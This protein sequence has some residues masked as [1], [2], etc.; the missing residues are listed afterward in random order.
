MKKS[1][2]PLL[3]ILILSSG[4]YA[5]DTLKVQTFTWDDDHRS[6]FFD[7]PDDD[8]VTYRK[9]LLRYNMRCHDAAVGNGSVGCY[10]WD[11]SCN[12]FITDPT[13]VDSTAATAPDYTISNF[14]GSEFP[15]N[16]LPT[17]SY[18]VYHQHNA[19]LMEG[20]NPIEVEFAP[21]GSPEP[22]T[23]NTTSFRYQV[24]LPGDQ[25]S[26]AGLTPGPISGLKMNLLEGGNTVGFF[27]IKLKNTPTDTVGMHPEDANLE[28]VYFKSTD[29]SSVGE[30]S[31]PFYQ[32]FNWEG[33]NL[34]MDISFTTFDADDAPVFDFSSTATTNAAIQSDITIA[35]SNV[36]FG[37]AGMMD[38]QKESVNNISN[39]ITIAFWSFGNPAILPANTSVAEGFDAAGRRQA[40]VHLPW[41]NGR[42]YWDCGN[43]GSGYDRIDK[44]ATPEEYEGQWN[45]WAFTKNT[46]SGIM[47]IYLNGQLW[48]TGEGRSKEIDIESFRFGKSLN[49]NNPYFGSI[50]EV[51]IWN[52]ELSEMTIRD[53]MYKHIDASHPDFQNLVAYYPLNEGSG[54]TA[55]DASEKMLD[56]ALKLPSWRTVRGDDLFHQF[57]RTSL[58]PNVTFLQGDYTITDNIVPTLDST[59]TDLHEV[60]HFGVSGTDL[61]AI[62]TQLLYFGGDRLVYDESGNILDTLAGNPDGSIVIGTLDYYSKRDAKFEILSLVTPYG[63]GLD[64]GP[65]GKTFVFDV[66]DF[67]P[68]LKGNRR[69]SLEYGGQNQ[70]ELDIQFWFITGTPER[71]VLNIQPIWPQARGNMT[72]I[73]QNR[74]FEP[75][76]VQLMP[77]ASYYKIR[78]AITG[79]GQNGEFIS[80]Q[81]FINVNG[82]SQEFPFDVWKACSLN[83]IYP[84]GGTWIFDRAGWCPGMETDVHSFP[85]DWYVTP[86]E[87]VTIDYGVNG[88]DMSEANYLVNNLLV[89]YGAYN[90]QTDASIEDVKRPNAD[91]VEYARLNPVCSS[92]VIVVKNS[93]EDLVESISFTYQT[94]PDNEQTYTWFGFLE[95]QEVKEIEL[96]LPDATFWADGGTFSVSITGVNGAPDGNSDNNHYRTRFTPT[97]IYDYVDPVQLR[98]QT[99]IPGSDYFYTIKDGDG[100][101]VFLRNNMSSNTV[102]TD[103]LNFPPGC[104][105]LDFR[106]SGNDGLSFWFFPDNGTGSLRFQRKLQSGGAIPLYSFNPDF[107]GGV[108]YD[109][110][111]GNINTANEEVNQPLQVFSTY[112]NPTYDEVN[113]DLFGFAQK[114]LHIELVDLTGHIMLEKDFRCEFDEET[115]RVDLFGIAPGTYFMHCTDGNRNWV[116]NVVVIR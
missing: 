43:D 108:L 35:A 38:L 110:I 79:H 101:V 42:V 78:A 111:L 31:L 12:T 25:L 20:V 67:G 66:T 102:Y 85:L 29:M 55:T 26:S 19:S 70:E 22:L 59:V 89:T 13:R 34:L 17:F 65:E 95:Q 73:L 83:P 53:W 63:N 96:P 72:A 71:D 27:K 23:P 84:Q 33:D 5:Q 32:S 50:D 69:L 4:M 51:Q 36:Y 100:N 45:H 11:Y 60:I 116:R 90:F 8:Q 7:F 40:N 18:T 39:E 104:Y 30:V 105:T 15:Y 77:S 24:V 10:E 86:G 92:P 80:R 107:G 68:V 49:N 94:R 115:T 75:R 62:D 44:E 82:G 52:K 76:D 91:R 64:L 6:D 16:L 87:L 2:A 37:G 1:I 28:E 14:S 48:H 113:I 88:G 47:N 114:D 106:D 99:N 61:V 93:G 41:S 97:T 81:H 98:L 54:Q 103:D 112:P 9:I 21:P 58:W 56:A 74:V 3:F 46:A 57:D 109:F